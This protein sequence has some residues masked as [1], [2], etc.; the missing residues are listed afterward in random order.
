MIEDVISAVDV[1]EPASS[2]ADAIAISGVSY[3][4]NVIRKPLFTFVR[5]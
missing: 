3:G 2:I 1:P 5:F 4:A